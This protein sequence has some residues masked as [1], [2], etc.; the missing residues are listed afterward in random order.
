MV[1]LLHIEDNRLDPIEETVLRTACEMI[2]SKEDHIAAAV[3]LPVPEV[4]NAVQ[5][6]KNRGLLAC[7]FRDRTQ[8]FSPEHLYVTDRGLDYLGVRGPSGHDEANRSQLIPRI[9]LLNPVYHA[10]DMLV[11]ELGI[12][13]RF[14][15]FTDA[16]LDGASFHERGWAGF[17]G[18]G[19]LES[20]LH[21]Q[22]RLEG[23]PH[24]MHELAV[25]PETP[26]PA[27]ILVIAKDSWQ[28]E[29]VRQAARRAF[30]PPQFL[31]IWSPGD[32]QWPGPDDLIP[33]IGEIRQPVPRRDLGGWSWEARLEQAIYAKTGSEVE[34]LEF[35][36]EWGELSANWMKEARGESPEGRT[37]QR[38]LTR[39]LATGLIQRRGARRSYTYFPSNRALEQLRLRDGIGAG[40]GGQTSEQIRNRL[41]RHETGMKEAMLP[42]IAAGYEVA[43]GTRSWEDMGQEGGGIS[44]DAMV[45][46][47]G[48]PFG[49]GWLYFEY[50][51]WSQD[52]E[53]VGNKLGGYQ[54]PLR[55]DDFPL[56]LACADD[57]AERVFHVVGR[58]MG[59]LMLTTT[60]ARL[61]Q[62]GPLGNLECWSLYGEM[63]QIS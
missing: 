20:D 4:T 62:H 18:S 28:K 45:R 9:P 41:L 59:I 35:V 29:L 33:S 50:E 24:R 22:R 32:G 57:E 11:P 60:I 14:Q 46:L 15:W 56:L 58:Q 53:Q 61:R 16:G 25:T 21:F 27:V 36:A 8:D 48:T 52:L 43:C 42:F 7:G 2:L 39:L 13:R 51:L 55:R 19:A 12:L 31:Q 30:F 54:S 26:R 40:Q 5:N 3:L 49:P 63:V 10:V 38:A 34:V 37:T 23:L 1:Q 44:P 17:M 47:N 6:L